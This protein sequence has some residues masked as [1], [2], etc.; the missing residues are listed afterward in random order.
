MT[1]IFTGKLV[2]AQRSCVRHRCSKEHG[3]VPPGQRLRCPR[4]VSSAYAVPFMDVRYF[5]AAP[6]NQHSRLY[7]QSEDYELFEKRE[8][9]RLHRAYGRSHGRKS[10]SSL[11]KCQAKAK[12]YSRVLQLR[13]RRLQNDLGSWF[14]DL[15]LANKSHAEELAL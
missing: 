15:L 1:L 14:G 11:H 13:Q 4:I 5:E 10:R 2:Y 12:S 8:R 3:Y 7:Y 9:G 6:K